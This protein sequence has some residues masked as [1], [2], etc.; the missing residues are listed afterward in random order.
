MRTTEEVI[1]SA[2]LTRCAG[3]TVCLE[4][5]AFAMG[6]QPQHLRCQSFADL[7]SAK[8]QPEV[9]VQWS[10]FSGKEL[11]ISAVLK[12]TNERC[13][14]GHGQPVT[15]VLAVAHAHTSSQP[16]RYSTRYLFC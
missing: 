12:S 5:I 8:G 2:L 3:K 7:L 16:A 13:G 9:T 14:P 10:T 4:A 6:A 11:N 15:I 1:A